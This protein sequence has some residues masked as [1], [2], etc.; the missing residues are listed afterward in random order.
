[1]KQ[2]TTVISLCLAFVA[3]VFLMASCVVKNTAGTNQAIMKLVD[4]GVDPTIAGCAIKNDT[5]STTCVVALLIH[6]QNNQTR[7][8]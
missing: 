8:E 2:H 7:K 1:M 5:R 3:S 6:Q 4:E